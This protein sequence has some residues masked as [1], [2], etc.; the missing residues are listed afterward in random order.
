MIKMQD[1]HWMNECLS[2]LVIQGVDNHVNT[3]S[4]FALSKVLDYSRN[5]R[6]HQDPSGHSFIHKD[7]L[8]FYFYFQWNHFKGNNYFILHSH[9]RAF[10]KVKFQFVWLFAFTLYCHIM[11]FPPP[12]LWNCDQSSYFGLPTPPPHT[13]MT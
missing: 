13:L 7:L 3:W 1:H 11:M 12:P 8:L 10:C 5:I 2:L 4:L 6:T 9:V